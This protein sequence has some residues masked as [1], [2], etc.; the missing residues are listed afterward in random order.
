MNE[1]V[2]KKRRFFNQKRKCDKNSSKKALQILDFF[3]FLGFFTL[4]WA[5]FDE[6][7]WILSVFCNYALRNLCEEHKT[8]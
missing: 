2:E 8:E 6:F 4:T 1:F 5:G 7:L 3:I